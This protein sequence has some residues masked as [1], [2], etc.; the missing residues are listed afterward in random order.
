[1][2]LTSNLPWWVKL[3][4]KLL[5]ARLP[6]SYSIWRKLK[7]FR[8][9]E[10]NKPKKAISTFQH[11][12]NIALRHSNIS[13]GFTVLELG[14]GDSILSG[15]VARSIGASKVWLVDASNFAET[16]LEACKKTLKLLEQ[17]GYN[18]LDLGEETTVD[19][20]LTKSNVHY[21]T[22]GILS[23][24][25]I[26]DSSIDFMWSQVVLEHVFRDEFTELLNQ[27]RRIL[28]PEGLAVHS[29]DFRDH[30]GNALNNLRFSEKTWESNLF[31]NSGF[32]TNRIRPKEMINLIE[33]AKFNVEILSEAYWPKIPTSRSV[34][35]APFKNLPDSEL[36]LAEYEILMTCKH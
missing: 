34:M 8:H 4:S 14:P 33:K 25:K 28:K 9:G 27:L 16:D 7:L 15:L 10:M 19:N 35:K 2:G 13:S 17:F 24:K 32:Y 23:L 36:R 5:L 20:I 11:Y 31:R 30:L 26:P 21:E 12:Y 6:V 3:Y 22:N 1:M 18:N 29:V